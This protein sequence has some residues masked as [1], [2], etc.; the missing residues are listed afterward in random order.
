MNSSVL[1]VDDNVHVCKLITAHLTRLPIEFNTIRTSHTTNDAMTEIIK[2]GFNFIILD[3]HFKTNKIDYISGLDLVRAAYGANKKIMVCSR[4][5]YAKIIETE[6]KK[7]IDKLSFIEYLEKPFAHEQFEQVFMKLYNA[8][9]STN[10]EV[11][12]SIQ[13]EIHKEKQNVFYKYPFL[14]LI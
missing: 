3:M 7:P 4:R 14:S 8:P 6:F 10:T 9:K 2:N 11:F 5:G 12:R 1:I 13:K